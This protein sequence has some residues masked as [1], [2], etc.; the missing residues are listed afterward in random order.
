MNGLYPCKMCHDLKIEREK[1]ER[2]SR[3][4][5]I[6][7]NVQYWGHFKWMIRTFCDI[8]V[9]F[10]IE[11]IFQKGFLLN[12]VVQIF[13]T[14][15]SQ[16][17]SHETKSLAFWAK[18]ELINWINLNYVIDECAEKSVNRCI[19]VSN[20]LQILFKELADC[21]NGRCLLMILWSILF[22]HWLS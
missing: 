12:D 20:L 17:N 14:L 15:K 2:R 9:E 13:E 11:H 6:Y 4:C 22:I 7:L 1:I 10:E 16:F 3:F 18:A 5:W 8:A 19:C 21:F